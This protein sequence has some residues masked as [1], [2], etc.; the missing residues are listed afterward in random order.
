MK[1]VLQLAQKGMGHVSPNPLVGALVVKNDQIL[2]EGYHA[3]FGGP[4]AEAAVLQKLNPSQ[5]ENSTLYVNLE[6]CVH[7]GKTPPCV[8]KIIEYDIAKV[9]IGMEDPNSL[10]KH[11][12]I[13]KLRSAGIE[14]EVGIME[15][16]CRRLNEAFVK[17]ITQK[18]PFI[19]LKIAQTLDGKIARETGES[20]WITSEKARKI[21]HKMRK[22]ADCVLVGVN[23]VIQDNCRLT[24]RLV[25]G[26]GGK[27]IILDSN[28][29]IPLDAHVIN[30]E[31][32]SDTIIV[33]T[34]KAPKD[35][36]DSIR[37]T[38]AQV[39]IVDETV[40]GTVD[41]GKLL[42]KIYDNNMISVLVEGGRKV[43]TSFLGQREV[44]K[45][46][47]FIAPRVFGKGVESFGYLEDSHILSPDS[48]K[49]IQWH[50]RDKEIIFKG[51]L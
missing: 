36:I 27:R 51:W 31:N 32:T 13:D 28:L 11:K 33:T 43:F 7:H 40:Q 34:A 10:V 29:R 19:T 45:I 37:K 50:K 12:G 15:N 30:D 39:W 6:P 1:R 48:F 42:K 18:K 35:K 47:I 8:D 26:D 41:I 46:V 5:A 23:T 2:S 25:P 44:D 16:Q 24:V 3:K 9:I 21:V 22:A 14:V 49:Q 20:K 17:S 38:G 4:H